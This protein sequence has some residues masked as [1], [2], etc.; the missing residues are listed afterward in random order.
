MSVWN[1]DPDIKAAE[2]QEW[3]SEDNEKIIICDIKYYSDQ[4]KIGYFSNYPYITP[5]GDS[6]TEKQTGY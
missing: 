4:E 3:L 5:F 1:A 2:Q 6:F